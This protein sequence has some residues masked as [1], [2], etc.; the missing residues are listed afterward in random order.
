M[1]KYLVQTHSAATPENTNFYGGPYAE[2]VAYYGKD[3]KMLALYG[4]EYTDFDLM[5]DYFIREY[6]YNRP[7]DAKR[8]W[9]YHNP[10][11]TKFWKTEVSVVSFEDL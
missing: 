1:T 2:N 7:Q 4:T 5:S 8:S 9:I 10:E 3:Q 11:N 6:G